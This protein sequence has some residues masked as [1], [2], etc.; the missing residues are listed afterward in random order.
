MSQNVKRHHLTQARE[1]F[2]VDGFLDFDVQVVVK[3]SLASWLIKSLV[4]VDNRSN[5]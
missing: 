2:D 1:S 5:I 4:R 3:R